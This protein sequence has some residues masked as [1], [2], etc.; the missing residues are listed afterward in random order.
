MRS[1]VFGSSSSADTHRLGVT[2][3]IEQSNYSVCSQTFLHIWDCGGQD[4]FWKGY[5]DASSRQI[6]SNVK[7]VV[8]VF[9]VRSE[10]FDQEQVY[11][12]NALVNLRQFSPEAK[13]Y[14]LLHKIDLIPEQKRLSFQQEKIKKITRSIHSTD[15]YPKNSTVLE[16][17]GE[18][19]PTGARSEGKVHFYSTSIRD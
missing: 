1:V 3:E 2:V 17:E 10:F 12:S 15:Q 13:I 19:L 14:C 9:D 5:L 16:N 4:I 7:C 6:F 11:F 8:F 18:N